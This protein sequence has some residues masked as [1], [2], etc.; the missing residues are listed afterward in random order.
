MTRGIIACVL[1]GAI[2]GGIFVGPR[3][4][5]QYD[6]LT[7]SL[8][9]Y[10]CFGVLSCLLFGWASWRAP[11]P[12]RWRPRRSDMTTAALLGL[13]GNVVYFVALVTAIQLT[14]IAYASLIVGLLPVTTTLCADWQERRAGRPTLAFGRLLP[15]LVLIAAG[16]AAVNVDLLLDEASASR[17]STASTLIGI[18]AAFIALAA[19]TAYALRNA[20]HVRAG[21]GQDSGEWATL[22]GIGTLFWV[23]LVAAGWSL[24]AA[25]TDSVPAPHV[26]AA[27][28]DSWFLA[29]S[30]YL[31]LGA[32]WVGTALWNYGARTLPATLSG[33]MIVFET[34]F[35]LMYGFGLEARGPRPLEM[36]AIVGLLGGVVW[37]SRLHTSP[38]PVGATP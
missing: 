1:A 10:L 33:Q 16:V 2:W 22:Q 8:A 37:A 19:W 12:R 23:V 9:R 28:T 17:Q 38:P 25:A 24:A 3:I 4:L 36:L 14:S 13:I 29:W 27:M 32:S 15:P 11:P 21:H 35:A 5:P 18:I 6:A 30:L 7:F 31:G 26:F 34:L 20:Q